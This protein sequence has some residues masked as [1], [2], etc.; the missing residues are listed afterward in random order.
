MFATHHLRWT[1]KRTMRLILMLLEMYRVKG[2]D[3]RFLTWI[4]HNFWSR[5]DHFPLFIKNITI[6]GKKG[7]IELRGLN[8]WLFGVWCNLHWCYKGELHVKISF[9]S[10]FNLDCKHFNEYP[11]KRAFLMQIE[12][13]YEP[14]SK[15]KHSPAL[16]A[17]PYNIL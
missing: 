4:F 17:E 15:I 14:N 8:V 1:R 12:R 11:L 5:F 9:K 6:W 10:K 7:Q 16:G 3:N 2:D 13:G